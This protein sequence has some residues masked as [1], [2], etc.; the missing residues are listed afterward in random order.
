MKDDKRGAKKIA[1]FTWATNNRADGEE[2]HFNVRG[3]GDVGVGHRP[4]SDVSA[5]D[6][7]DANDAV[8]AHSGWF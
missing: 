4:R 1:W 7:N 2:D 5:N 3:T 6:A 8:S